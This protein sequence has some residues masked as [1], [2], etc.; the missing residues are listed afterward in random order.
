[1]CLPHSCHQ[2]WPKLGHRVLQFTTSHQKITRLVPDALQKSLPSLST[3]DLE[4]LEQDLQQQN[5]PP[6]SQLPQFHIPYAIGNHTV[7]AERQQKLMQQVHSA[8]QVRGTRARMS[9]CLH[10]L[11]Q[12]ALLVYNACV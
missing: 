7:S 10:A 2:R 6:P 12:C 9:L 3:A 4:Q 8:L 11:T 5:L 1:M